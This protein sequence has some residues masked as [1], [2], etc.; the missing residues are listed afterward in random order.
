MQKRGPMFCGH[1]R[2]AIRSRR[3]PKEDLK[4][5]KTGRM[6]Q[7]STNEVNSANF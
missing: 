5:Q 4:A 6:L 1:D 2:A 7:T 3:G